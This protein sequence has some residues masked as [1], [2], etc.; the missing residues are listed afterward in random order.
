MEDQVAMLQKE[1]SSTKSV[2][3]STQRHLQEERSK[4]NQVVM[5]LNLQQYQRHLE[6]KQQRAK[7]D[8]QMSDVMSH[9]L[10][11]EG[12]L[13]REQQK[14][15]KELKNRAEQIENQ[16]REIV[17][18]KDQNEQLMNA[19]KEIYAKGG[20]NGYMRESRKKNGENVE[21][22]SKNGKEK[23]SHNGRFGSMREK[24]MAKNRSSLELN[25]FNL[26]KYLIKNDRLCSSH[27]ELHRITDEHRKGMSSPL[28]CETPKKSLNPKDRSPDGRHAKQ[29]HT[30]VSECNLFKPELNKSTSESSHL[31][32]T[33]N[34]SGIYSLSDLDLSGQDSLSSPCEEHDYRN[35]DDSDRIFSFSSTHINTVID[36]E[37]AIGPVVSQGQMMSMGSMPMLANLKE[38]YGQT[39]GKNRPHSLSSV[40]LLSIEQQA[41]HSPSV[42]RGTEHLIEQ[43]TPPSSPS[44]TQTKTEL[45]PFQTFKTMFRRKG[46]K[47]KGKKR[48]VSLSQTTNKEYS[49]ALKKHFQKYDMS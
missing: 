26:E 46:S 25:N 11:L 12:R 37:E 3:Q 5:N 39:T 28:F 42:N 6:L 41:K 24:L 1:L 38:E 49:E 35:M 32:E 29:F 43:V 19:I 48:S 7:S 9:L 20:M 14:V 2:L 33:T 27:E 34:S 18:L 13:R 36:E 45:T 44:S 17:K 31:S 30:G 21:N 22:G 10:F 47:N 8:A 23:K 16:K 40:D 15:S 4:H